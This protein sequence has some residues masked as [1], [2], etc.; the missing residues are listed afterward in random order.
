VWSINKT[1]V[2]T[3]S[4]ASIQAANALFPLLVFPYLFLVFGET[5]FS[6]I[7]I[8]EAISLYILAV[9]LYS[10][11]VLGVR[12]V[13]EDLESGR[14]GLTYYVNILALRTLLFFIIAVPALAIIYFTLNDYFLIFSI[15]LLF[16]VGSILQSNYYFQALENNVVLAMVIVL[17]RLAAVLF[18]Y[19]YVVGEGDTNLAVLLL[20]GSFFVSGVVSFFYVILTQAFTL[21]DVDRGLMFRLLIEGKEIFIGNISVALFRGANVLILSVVSNASAVAVYSLAEKFI[22]SW[23]AVARPLNQVFIPKVIKAWSKLALAEKSNQKAFEIVWQYSRIQIVLMLLSI[24]I[25]FFVIGLASTFELLSG[26][27]NETFILI[28]IMSLSVVSGIANA[29]FGAVGLSLIDSQRYF[30]YSVMMVGFS[31]MLFSFVASYYFQARGGAL[32]YVLSECL[33]LLVFIVK[34]RRSK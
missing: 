12:Y 14:D 33:L 19:V 9:S 22:K 20:A 23:Q 13:I 4:L 26:F 31:S 34:Y 30:A 29:M 6:H 2:N 32:A 25:V 7:V 1:V 18:I 28:A 15:W 10:F 8:A 24:P 5:E 16:V 11:D 27:S 21:R 17:S 3:I